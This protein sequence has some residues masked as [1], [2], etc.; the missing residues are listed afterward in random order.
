[1]RA[2]QCD[3]CG[4][5]YSYFSKSIKREEIY[6]TS[7]NTLSGCIKDLCGQCQEE[8]EAWWKMKKK[9]KK[10]KEAENEDR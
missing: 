9:K 3:R 4:E 5:L 6:I 10:E 7:S 8:L 2:Y 1:M